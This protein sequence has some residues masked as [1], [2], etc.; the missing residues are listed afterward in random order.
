[1]KLKNSFILI[2]ISC[3]TTISVFGQN[4]IESFVFDKKTDRPIAYV[5]VGFVDKN[6]RIITNEQGSFNLK[7][8]QEDKNN[9]SVVRFSTDGYKTLQIKVLE[10]LKTIKKENK[11]YLIAKVSNQEKIVVSQES[12]VKL[13]GIIHGKVLT[14]LGPLERA[15]INIKNTFIEEQTDSLGEFSLNVKKGDIL[16]VNYL[17]MKEK[18]ILISDL[19]DLKIELTSGSEVL[20]EVV[21]KGE[22][23]KEEELID[24]G[25]GGKKSFDAI[26]TSNIS[27]TEK[28]IGPQYQY[29][30]DLLMGKFA[31]VRVGLFDNNEMPEVWLPGRVNATMKPIP[32]IYDIDGRIYGSG[33]GVYAPYVD[34]QNIKSITI[35]KSLAATN[36]Y[37]SIAFGGVVVIKTKTFSNEETPEP[38]KS[39]MVKDNLYSEVIPLLIDVEK[40][41]NYIKNLEKAGSYQEALN[42][43][44]KQKTITEPL[45]VAF[46]LDVSEYFM[47]WDADFSLSVLSKIQKI[48]KNNIK[49][50][51]TLAFRYEE[52]N[53]LQKAK[54][55]YER[56]AVLNSTDAQSYRDLAHIYTLTNNFSEAMN[57]YKKMLSN[58]IKDIDFTGLQRPIA[59]EVMHML[60]LYKSKVD[61]KDLPS[62]YFPVN[63]KLDVRIV[64]EWND[65]FA[66]FDLQ[67]VNPQKKYFGWSHTKYNNEDR[68]LDEIKNGYYTKEFTIDGES[69]GEWIINIQSFNDED[70][71]NPIYLKYTIFKNYGLANETKSVKLVKLYQQKQKVTLNKFIY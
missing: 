6:I 14:N 60:A 49:A 38:K 25:L 43:Y 4:E 29:F 39:A 21:L 8:D 54:S 11:I 69:N 12:R 3:F 18:E 44:E 13:E 26:G 22:I 24:L 35:L 58:S 28:D 27:M 42:I 51:K 7:Y 63:F 37:G 41:P 71:L 15:T 5:V 2:L 10:L 70:L 17:G 52:V 64:F 34:P 47:R 48:G 56:I 23:K 68:L 19:H 30:R 61:F 9:N 45:G 16:R 31:G 20:E 33:R 50:L 32:A 46:Y 62:D 1:M 65:P 53:K 36:K 40:K 59:N 66:E 57:L 67:F 55:I